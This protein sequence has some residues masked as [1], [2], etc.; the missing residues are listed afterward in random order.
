M[1]MTETPAA[2]VKPKRHARPNKRKKV[3]KAQP[4]SEFEGL[5]VKTCCADCN[6][7]RCVITG[8]NVCGHPLKGGIQAAQKNDHKVVSRFTRAKEFLGG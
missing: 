1:T 6:V 7:D 3:A 2:P 5:S 4:V 8:I